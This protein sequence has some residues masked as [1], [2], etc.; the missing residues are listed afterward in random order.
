MSEAL[1]GLRVLE[2]GN[3]VAG[4]YAASV[5]ADFGAEVIRVEVPG[6][7][8]DSRRT[9]GQEPLDPGRSPFFAAGLGRNKR[10]LSLDVRRPDGRLLLLELA[11]R[12]DVLVEN[13]Q[14]GRLE[15]WGLGPTELAEANPGLVVL[16]LSGYGQ[17]GSWS[18][19]PG[20]D[21][22]AQ[23]FGGLTFLTGQPDGPPLPAGLVVADYGAAVWGVVG[24]LLALQERER[25]GRGQVVDVALYASLL[26]MLNEIPS[27]YLM[28]GEVRRRSGSH[29][30][31]SPLLQVL[32]TASG[33][34]IQLAALGQRDFERLARAMDR[35]DLLSDPAYATDNARERNR[36]A[37]TAQVAAWA[38]SL[39]ADDCLGR[40]ERAGVACSPIHDIA[41][42]MA[43]PQ[44]AERHDFQEVLDPVYGPLPAIATPPRLS[45]TPASQPRPGPSLGADTDGILSGLLGLGHEQIER[46][47]R[48][49]VV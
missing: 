47:R 13:L 5:L 27:R 23:A 21:R 38:A 6:R 37:L 36:E 29:Y 4:P 18:R 46:L 24:V 22:A 3:F 43:H 9:G 39:P 31:R 19:R 35:S 8:D 16:R 11:A 12:S 14:P 28:H 48:A 7:I 32:E 30:P 34:W 1:A 20:F 49:G 2:I 25:S 15:E 45:R 40:L 33:E 10:S 42:L 44:V 26:P 41:A 17:T